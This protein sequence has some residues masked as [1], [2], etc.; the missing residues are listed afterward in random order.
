MVKECL[1]GVKV[2][3][4]KR[5]EVW[6]AVKRVLNDAECCCRL[7]SRTKSARRCKR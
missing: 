2:S 3:Q 6:R 5:G 4:M 1:F 7:D